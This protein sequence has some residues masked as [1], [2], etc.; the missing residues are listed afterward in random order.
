MI[1]GDREMFREGGNEGRG[2][3]G[4]YTLYVRNGYLA[5]PRLVTIGLTSPTVSHRIILLSLPQSSQA[6]VSPGKAD[7]NRT[8]ASVR[9]KTHPSHCFRASTGVH[10][11]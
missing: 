8:S 3:E 2:R 9:H 6:L 11:G 4:T 10:Y 7:R 1:D 5:C